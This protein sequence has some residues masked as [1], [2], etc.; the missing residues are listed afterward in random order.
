MVIYEQQ[1]GELDDNFIEIHGRTIDLSG[2][3]LSALTGSP[4]IK[5]NELH[6]KLELE[7]DSIIDFNGKVI[8]C[9]KNIVNDELKYVSSISF[10]DIDYKNREKIVGFIFNQQRLLLKKELR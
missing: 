10:T 1:S 4:L 5:N 9:I 2:G 3:G 7:D 6:G 8:R